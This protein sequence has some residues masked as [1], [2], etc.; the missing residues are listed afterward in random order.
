MNRRKF[1]HATAL[2][3]MGLSMPYAELFANSES[4]PFQ[5]EE[6]KMLVFNLL[7]DWCDGMIEVQIM[8]PSDPKLHGLLDCPAC[9]T[10]HGRASDAVYPFFYL[11]K[12]TGDKKY[13]NAGI[14]VFEWSQNVSQPDGSWTNDINPNSWNG[15]TVFGAIALAETLKYHGDL[16][17]EVR[18]QNW[19]NR[20]GEAAEFIYQKFPAIDSTNVNYGATNIYA[21]NLIGNL[22]DEP[23]YIAL[24]KK[25]ASEVK[26]YFTEDNALLYGEIKPSAHQRSEKGLPGIDLGYNV[27]ESLNSLVLYALHEKDEELL[28]IVQKSLESHMEFMLPDGGFDNSWGTRMFKWTYWGS[29]T[30]DGCQPAFSLMAGYNP[31]FGTAAFKNTEL[32]KRCTTNGLLHGGP[33]YVSHGIKPCIHHTFTHTKSLAVILDHWDQ[34]PPITKTN[35]L[36]RA[37]S[38]GLRYFEE[39][40]TVLFARGDWRGTVSAY[41]AEYY[42][43]M[44]LRQATGNSLGMLYHSRVGLLCAAS[45]AVYRLMEPLNQQDA[46]GKDIALTPRVETYQDGKWFTNLYDLTANFDS[47]DQDG[48]IRIS[49]DVNLKNEDR[50]TLEGSA[51]QF[52][53]TYFCSDTEL[54]ILVETKQSIKGKTSFTLPIISKNNEPVEQPEENVILITKPEG[55]VRI[56]ANV[57]LS[58]IE[59]QKSRT[60]NMVPGVEALP[61]KVDFISNRVEL[62]LTVI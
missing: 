41:D 1:I 48:E 56:A 13:L 36:P 62:I 61:I 19:K 18:Y 55:R 46:P 16:L 10:I 17:D 39:L 38:N 40:D 27:E 35:P 60:F 32:L 3:G 58:I 34:M 21:M 2:T 9:D 8:D 12:A 29:R 44:D 49:G 7:K 31:A 26:S 14:T 42:P 20:L 45:L 51:S 47:D 4:I 22:L 24:S 6:Y 5:S 30:C 25:L 57:S 28:R 37:A 52:K 33:H 15:T 23:N 50:E 54:R 53:I 43:K 59:T 11:A